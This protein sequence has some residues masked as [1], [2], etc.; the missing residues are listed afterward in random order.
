MVFRGNIVSNITAMQSQWPGMLFGTFRMK[1][2][3]IK[4]STRILNNIFAQFRWKIQWFSLVFSVLPMMFS[5][6]NTN[7]VAKNMKISMNF[8]KTIIQNRS[9]KCDE[10]IFH[11]KC[12]KQHSWPLR[13]SF[14]GDRDAISSKNHIFFMIF[15][16]CWLLWDSYSNSIH[17]SIALLKRTF[18]ARARSRK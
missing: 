3:F 4:I 6:I 10:N 18:F 8:S 12:P 17:C 9:W 1:N 7:F 5:H 11:E 13:Q 16:V 2:I 14:G 15:H